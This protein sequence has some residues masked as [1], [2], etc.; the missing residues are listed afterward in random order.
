MTSKRHRKFAEDD[1]NFTDLDHLI[2]QLVRPRN[3]NFHRSRFP[4]CWA[5][6]G[7]S[8]PCEACHP[9]DAECYPQYAERH[10]I[11]GPDDSLGGNELDCGLGDELAASSQTTAS[12]DF[13][14]E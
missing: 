6:H 9:R 10:R 8:D 4:P 3:P 14:M 11:S 1:T 13:E 2:S 5:P 7:K 12:G